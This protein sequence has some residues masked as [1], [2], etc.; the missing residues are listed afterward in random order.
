MKFSAALLKRKL[1]KSQGSD[2]PF[3]RDGKE[4]LTSGQKRLRDAVDRANKKKS[5]KK[6][7]TSSFFS[8]FKRS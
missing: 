5:D 2:E 4:K 7:R 1:R 6:S 8:K 3:K